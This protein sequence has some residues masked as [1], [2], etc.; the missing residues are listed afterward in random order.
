MYEF[1]T[2]ELQIAKVAAKN[3]EHSVENPYA[4]Y[5][6]A[7]SVEEILAS[8][9]VCDPIRLLEICA[10]NEGAAAVILS[11]API[12]EVG[13]RHQVRIAG[14]AHVLA[15]FSADWRAPMYATS[16]K[17]AG[18][19]PPTSRAAAL[20]FNEAGI[21]PDDID[22][23]ELQDTDAFCELEAYEHLGLCKPGESGRLIDDGI[24]AL[25]GLKPVNV[26]GG[27]ISKGEPVGAS[28]L[29][30][31]VELVTQLRGEAGPRQISGA[32]VGLAHVLG[33]AGNCAV[34]VLA[35]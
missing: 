26:S 15:E 34:T 8:P 11:K 13:S 14:S 5:R 4:M 7:F 3:H 2:T 28:H 19:V 24:T 17:A 18:A 22:C 33:A 35:R 27:L 21:G 1:G 12:D 23:F 25:G 32:K 20:A 30:Q 9:M 10:P 6:N 16:A 29:G 31:I